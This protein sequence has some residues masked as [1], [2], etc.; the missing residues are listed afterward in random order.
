MSQELQD[1]IHQVIESDIKSCRTIG[2][3]IDAVSKYFLISN[4]INAAV[5]ADIVYGLI[6][7]H[8]GFTLPPNP[9]EDKDISIHRGFFEI[10]SIAERW[11]QDIGS[12]T[13]YFYY[14][15]SGVHYFVDSSGSIMK[16]MGIIHHTRSYLV[17]IFQDKLSIYHMK[18]DNIVY[19]APL[20]VLGNDSSKYACN[21][22]DLK[23]IK[24]AET[25]DGIAMTASYDCGTNLYQ[26][27]MYDSKKNAI[28]FV[29][30][31]ISENRYRGLGFYGYYIVDDKSSMRNRIIEYSNPTKQHHI[32]PLSRLYKYKA[33]EGY[34]SVDMI[35]IGDVIHLYD[36]RDDRLTLAFDIKEWCRFFEG[37]VI[38][39]S[40]V[41]DIV[42]G[43]ELYH[44]PNNC[45]I[46]GITRK[47]DN[48]GYHIWLERDKVPS[49]TLLQKINAKYGGKAHM[50]PFKEFKQAVSS[51]LSDSEEDFSDYSE[52][53]ISSD[54]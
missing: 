50:S 21:P 20:T 48:S 25:I 10:T 37:F 44:A 38:Y 26:V 46:Y 3:V 34:K 22:E 17:R 32:V 40:F 28:V 27:Y 1:N 12:W 39:N 8:F 7:K 29:Q 42:T 35:T 16:L 18:L 19:E 36:V 4:K 41:L 24:I 43:K 30:E 11:N 51:E 33:A 5:N 31:V 23:Y 49:G 13:Y 2:E 6:F 53:E 52:D 54:Y 15:N 9:D 14:N 47:N 45:E